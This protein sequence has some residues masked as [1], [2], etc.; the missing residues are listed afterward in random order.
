[1]LPWCLIL[2]WPKA[3]STV[4]AMMA[5]ATLPTVGRGAWRAKALAVSMALSWAF[6]LL[7]PERVYSV[8]ALVCPSHASAI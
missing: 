4:L 3:F 5:P 1:V 6:T 2:T 8:F 7:Q